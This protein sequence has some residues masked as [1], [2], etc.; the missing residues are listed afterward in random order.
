MSLQPIYSYEEQ[1][2]QLATLVEQIHVRTSPKVHGA[3]T[4]SD[5]VTWRLNQIFLP[6]GWTCHILDGPVI[7]TIGDGTAYVR[8]TVRLSVTFANG[9]MA[10]RDDVGVWPLYS[11]GG[12]NGDLKTTPPE[13]FETVLKAAVSDA[14]KAAAER[15]GVTFR[16]LIDWELHQHLAAQQAISSG[17]HVGADQA[18]E[19][20]YGTKQQAQAQTTQATPPAAPKPTANGEKAARTS[21]YQLTSGMI[22]ASTLTPARFNALTK[23]AQ[24]DGWVKVLDLLQNE[25]PELPSEPDNNDVPF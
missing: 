13:N 5:Y 4:T 20:L 23:Q 25:T 14:L 24:T 22:R 7:E 19:E 12:A 15:L 10:E 11:K 8:A 9:T 1:L 17:P 18:V 6:A 16:V 3:Y 2:E 21:F